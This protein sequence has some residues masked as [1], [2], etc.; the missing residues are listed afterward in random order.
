MCLSSPRAG[1]SVRPSGEGR[2]HPRRVISTG[3]Q[4][5]RRRSSCAPVRPVGGQ[6]GLR[7][8]HDVNRSGSNSERR[9]ASTRRRARGPPRSPETDEASLYARPEIVPRTAVHHGCP[10]L[11]RTRIATG[12]SEA[13]IHKGPPASVSHL[14]AP[15][16][17]RNAEQEVPSIRQRGQPRA[18]SC[19]AWCGVAACEGRTRFTRQKP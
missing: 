11:P 10:S 12:D 7:A 9:M 14:S 1:S 8:A 19:D 5:R 3:Q 4:S 2:P 15:P 6:N 18:M 16:S 13:F 17:R